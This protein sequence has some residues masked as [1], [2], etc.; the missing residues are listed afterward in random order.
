VGRE[1]GA[2]EPDRRES[3]MSIVNTPTAEDAREFLRTVN[4]I[5]E[6]IG[7]PQ[8]EKIPYSEAEPGNTIGC[9]GYTTVVKPLVDHEENKD[10][11]DAISGR[12]AHGD[13]SSAYFHFRDA[14]T[15]QRVAEAI[16]EEVSGRGQDDA[17][18][19]GLIGPDDDY[20]VRMPEAIRAM[21]GPFDQ[22]AEDEALGVSVKG[23]DEDQVLRAFRDAGIEV[24]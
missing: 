21:T 22:M 11:G 16:G 3:S 13:V 6:A 23:G 17:E 20:A 10:Q 24:E 15:A 8:L 1:Q 9:L 5:R 14:D 18:A 4:T 12:G 7:V 2:E 19:L